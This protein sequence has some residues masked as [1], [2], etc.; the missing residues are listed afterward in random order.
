M[1]LSEIGSEAGG[2][3]RRFLRPFTASLDRG[4]LQKLRR[5]EAPKFCPN[6]PLDRYIH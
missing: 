5:L 1:H 2:L 6:S 4:L 3:C